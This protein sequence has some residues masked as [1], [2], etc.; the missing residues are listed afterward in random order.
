[1][2]SAKIAPQVELVPE[3]GKE[4]A[5]T[6]THSGRSIDDIVSQLD[7][8]IKAMEKESHPLMCSINNPLRA[9]WDVL[10]IFCLLYI[11]LIV[12]LEVAFDEPSSFGWKMLG[13][14]VDLILWVDIAICFRTT[15][16]DVHGTGT[17]FSL[18]LLL[19]TPA[20]LFFS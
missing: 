1:M 19:S 3:K 5:R 20:D 2:S 17:L 4:L 15:Y 10:I 18:S 13:I 9:S 16:I 6:E 7:T 12:P 11:F 14:T 8:T